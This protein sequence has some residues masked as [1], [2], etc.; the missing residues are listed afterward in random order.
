[1]TPN[2]RPPSLMI[3]STTELTL[4]RLQCPL[5]TT[6][7]PSLANK[8]AI[9]RP[10]FCPDP[11]ITAVTLPLPSC[12]DLKGARRTQAAVGHNY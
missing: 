12:P 7:A 3:S 4:E 11:V 1:M 9:A 10:I 5:I 2:A 8:R 6:A